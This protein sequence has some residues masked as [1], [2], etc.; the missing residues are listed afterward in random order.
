MNQKQSNKIQSNRNNQIMKKKI[1]IG[2]GIILVIIQFIRPEKNESND[3]TYAISSKYQVTE[4]VKHLLQVSC[5]D[6][7]SNNTKYPWYAEVQPITWWL[8]DH[9][10]D[11]K[12]HLN[13]SEFTNKPIAIQNHKLEE[14]I[15]EVK[16]HEMPLASYTYLGLHKKANLNDAQRKVITNWASAQMDLLK[17][18]YP[19]DSLVMPRKK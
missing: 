18:N 13:F 4:E 9:I 2:L 12:R 8:N 14:I 3:L 1:F 17:A 10:I 19:A 11:G 5:N 6:C 7:H 16:E 15:E